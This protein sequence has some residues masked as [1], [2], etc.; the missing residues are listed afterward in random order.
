MCF[1]LLIIT[2]KIDKNW[3]S[4]K[5]SVSC[6]LRLYNILYKIEKRGTK[7][8][9]INEYITKKIKII[10]QI[11]GRYCKSILYSK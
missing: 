1:L 6:T 4:G 2:Y 7:K 9:L 8:Y 5:R 3:I 10:V 11:Y